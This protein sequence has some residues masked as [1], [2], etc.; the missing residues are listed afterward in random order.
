LK[1]SERTICAAIRDGKAC[2]VRQ[3]EACTEAGGGCTAC[4]PALEKLLEREAAPAYLP[5]S[6]SFSTR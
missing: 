2:S 3:I 5:S 4:H 1:V 6:P